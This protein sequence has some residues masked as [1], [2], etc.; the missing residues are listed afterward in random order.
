MYDFMQNLSTFVLPDIEF[1]IT[2]T[3]TIII[4]TFNTKRQGWQLLLSFFFYF[5]NHTGL[6]LSQQVHVVQ[7]NTRISTS[8]ADPSS[9][10][11]VA[12]VQYLL[13]FPP[14]TYIFAGDNPLWLLELFASQNDDGT[15]SKKLISP[16]LL[17]HEQMYEA[18]QPRD[19]ISFTASER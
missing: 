14:S 10:V 18:V 16:Q 6:P 17:D 19:V 7:H 13:R 4:I 12:T 2:S 15:G 9:N 1:N 3:T 8:R 11:M 5:F